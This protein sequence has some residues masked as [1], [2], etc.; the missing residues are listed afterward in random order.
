L[1]NCFKNMPKPRQSIQGKCFSSL[2]C[3]FLT[4]VATKLASPIF[5]E[6]AMHFSL[7]SAFKYLLKLTGNT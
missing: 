1:S 6:S 7:F 2:F 4:C 3:I 5:T